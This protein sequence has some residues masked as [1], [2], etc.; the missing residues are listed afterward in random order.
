[1]DNELDVYL[2]F[3]S[4][5]LGKEHFMGFWLFMLAMDLLIPITMIGFGWM[6][7]HKVPQK[8][9]HAFG[10]RSY[11]SLINKDTWAFAHKYCGRIWYICGIYMIPVSVV[12]LLFVIGKSV[13]IIGR[14]GGILCAIQSLLLAGAVIPTEIKLKKV[15]DRNGRRRELKNEISL[16]KQHSG[17][18]IVK[19]FQKMKEK[20]SVSILLIILF[21]IAGI[22]LVTVLH[23]KETRSKGGNILAGASPDTSAFQMYYFDGEA[24]TVRTLYDARK[25]KELIKKINALPLEPADKNALSEMEVPFYGIWISNQDGYDISIALSSGVWLRNDGTVYYGDTDL[26][27]LWEQMEGEDEDDA[28]TVLN[29]PN[30]GILSAYHPFFMLEAVEPD[31]ET[32]KGIVMSVEDIQS[33]GITVSITNNSGEE[34]SYGKYFSLQKQ[35]DSKWYTM[36]VQAGNVGFEDIAYV[37]QDGKAA[38][39]TYDLSIYG[40][41]EPGIYRLIIENIS[42]EFTVGYTDDIYER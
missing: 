22:L 38:N 3:K 34:F 10:Y 8:I 27:A 17:R 11:M 42:A 40:T 14:V 21:V 4:T 5:V 20:R 26:S 29:F 16:P 37:L 1:M 18:V 12:S 2:Y 30:A 28:L 15:F 13:N 35:I 9:N 25:E 33:D 32:V 41:L 7:M 36:P 31:Q 24:V 19:L 39:E 6:F 23:G